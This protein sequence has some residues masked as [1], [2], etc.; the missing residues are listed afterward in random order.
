MIKPLIVITAGIQILDI[1]VHAA[2]NQLEILRVSSNIIILAWLITLILNKADK[3]SRLYSYASLSLYLLLNILFLTQ[4]G[5]TNASQGG[6][7]R[8]A[9]ILFMLATIVLSIVL[10]RL[11][12]RLEHKTD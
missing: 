3:K 6:D 4:E 2:T 7:L 8:I 9:L 1:S 10:V 5:L 11:V 12:A